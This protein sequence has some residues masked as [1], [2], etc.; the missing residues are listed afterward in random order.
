[1]SAACPRCGGPVELCSYTDH[2]GREHTGPYACRACREYVNPVSALRVPDLPWTGMAG[3]AATYA[4]EGWYV[5]PFRLNGKAKH[6]GSVLRKGWPTKTSNDPARA[7]RWFTH[8]RDADADR[9]DRGLFLHVGRSGAIAFDA[10]HPEHLHPLLRKAITDT[11]PVF[12]ATRGRYC[13][14]FDPYDEPFGRGHYLWALPDGVVLGNGLGSL[15][16]DPK[17]GEVRGTNGVIVVEPTPHAKAGAPEFGVYQWWRPG[18]LPVLPTKVAR[19]LLGLDRPKTKNRHARNHIVRPATNGRIGGLIGAVL[20]ADDGKQR[21]LLFWAAC[22]FGEMIADDVIN[23]EVV[24]ELL[25][26][27]GMQLHSYDPTHP[28]AEDAV[29]TQVD[30]GLSTGKWACS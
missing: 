9:T 11:R 6:A 14:P 3:A 12:Q 24:R 2:R 5:G 26:D 1:M 18:V 23:E 20:D 4:R 8:P 27:T 25:I 13:P 7:A 17:W 10:D 19:A 30:S 16:T 15:K 21:E 28:W 22:R 29:T